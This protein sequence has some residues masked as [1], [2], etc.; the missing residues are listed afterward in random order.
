MNRGNAKMSDVS[1]K[2]LRRFGNV[3]TFGRIFKIKKTDS[4]YIVSERCDDY[5]SCE[6]T[7]YEFLQ[8][9]EKMKK[10]S[11]YKEGI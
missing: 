2:E 9:I 3:I 8:L 6:M 11:E 7:E 4:G 1:F 5:F 10:L